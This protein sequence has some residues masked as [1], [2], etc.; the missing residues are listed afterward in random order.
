MLAAFL[1]TALLVA[2]PDTTAR[3]LAMLTA[4]VQTYLAPFTEEGEE[5]TLAV[6][7]IDLTGDGIEDA[8]VTVESPSWCGS[9][10]CTLL[11]LEA[12]SGEHAEEFGPFRV[13]AEIAYTNGEVTVLRE[14]SHGWRDLVVSNDGEWAVLQFDGETYPTSPADALAMSGSL[15]EGDLLFAGR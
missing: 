6:E 13:A 5:P 3:P 1:A 15:P 4:S 7:W 11:V 10:G 2:S 8:L 12:M 14:S 9:G